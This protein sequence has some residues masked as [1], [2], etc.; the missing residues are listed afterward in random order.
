LS[1]YVLPYDWPTLFHLL[2]ARESMT[3]PPDAWHQKLHAYLAAVPRY[4]VHQLSVALS[5]KYNVYVA[6]KDQIMMG[7][8]EGVE[9]AIRRER[10]KQMM[11]VQ[12]FEATTTTNPTTPGAASQRPDS[13]NSPLY[14]ASEDPGPLPKALFSSSEGHS[15]GK[16]IKK[17]RLRSDPWGITRV[18]LVRSLG[19]IRASIL[20]RFRLGAQ[21]AGIGAG[22][23]EEEEDEEERHS[24]SISDMGNYT[25]VLHKKAE[26]ELRDPL[27]DEEDAARPINFGS[28]FRK[29]MGV[30][31]VDEAEG[32]PSDR[33]RPGEGPDLK[34]KGPPRSKRKTA[35]ERPSFGAFLQTQ[36]EGQRRS[37]APLSEPAR[38]PSPPK[39]VSFP[40]TPEPPASPGVRC[41]LFWRTNDLLAFRRYFTVHVL[42]A[43]KPDLVQLR[44]RLARIVGEDAMRKEFLRVLFEE[45]REY[46]RIPIISLL[47]L[48]LSDGTRANGIT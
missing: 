1:L 3:M 34:G 48:E 6:T 23:E 19:T 11:L 17:R 7:F 12:S 32:I 24:L 41:A 26:K 44:S 8:S 5:A 21:G 45:A 33:K 43:Q 38:A 47:H 18:D 42:R 29:P 4:Y 10:H 40:T 30:E 39:S 27:A 46:N 14:A 2:K 22:K 37:Q 15:N 9:E 16:T 25:E 13:P 28:P 31:V 35:S 20:A 36:K